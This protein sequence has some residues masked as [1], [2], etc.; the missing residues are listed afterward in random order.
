MV[1]KAKP[2]LASKSKKVMADTKEVLKERKIEWL[3]IVKRLS[4]HVAS[5]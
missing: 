3:G 1:K 4:A 5:V 2:P